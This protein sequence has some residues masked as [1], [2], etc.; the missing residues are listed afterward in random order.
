MGLVVLA[1]R[2]RNTRRT[3]AIL[4][5]VITFWPR[6]NHPLTPPSYGGRTVFDLRLRMRV[7]RE[8]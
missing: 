8:S 5:D 3:V 2:N 1:A 6:A 4:W 7:L